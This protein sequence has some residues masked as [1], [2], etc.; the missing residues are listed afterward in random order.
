MK[1]LLLS[2]LAIQGSS[3][4]AMIPP[5]LQSVSIM[6]IQGKEQFS[7]L[8]LHFVETT[9]VVTLVNAKKDGFWMQDP[10]GDGDPTTSD[11]LYVTG[12]P[13]VVTPA[14][15]DSVRILGRVEEEQRG[16]ELPRTR[17]FAVQSPEVLSQ[18]TFLPAPVSL[19]RLPDVSIAEGIAFW[20]ALEG[21]R[22]SV[23]NAVVISPTNRYR[24]FNVL[25]PG[26][27]VPGSGYYSKSGRLLVRSLGGEK[28]DYNPER[29]MIGDATVAKPILVSA[30]DRL[31]SLVGVV[32]Y[33]FNYYKVQ[34][35]TESVKVEAREIPKPPVS[36]RTGP[37]G[38]FVI[39]TYNFWDY[40]DSIPNGKNE[41]YIYK[42]EQV[43]VRVT[44]MAQSFI[45]ELKLPQIVAVNEVE[46]TAMDKV[47]ER[48]NTLAGT[49]YKTAWQTTS[50]WR[51]LSMG[52]IYDSD[53]VKLESLSQI[54][55]AGVG[56]AFGQKS[57]IGNREPLV[58]VFSVGEGIP[59]VTVIA[60]KIKTKRMEDS[61]F[62][63][64]PPFRFT[65]IQRKAQ[66]RVIRKYLNALF[67][68]NPD[69]YV[70]VTGDLADYD[71]PEPGEGAD[72]PLA[73][74]K[75][76]DGEVP[77]TNLSGR[78]EEAERYDYIF[79]GGGVLVS[80]IL[81]S[82][83]LLKAFVA[84]DILHFNTGFPDQLRWDVS[85]PLKASDR[86]PLEARFNLVARKK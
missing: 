51:G 80:H 18:G 73:I 50:D 56:G 33:T 13:G 78:E 84:A 79:Q 81:V 32:D 52:F 4:E 39:T 28:V 38:N 9:G 53:R 59:P 34:P 83:A 49:H 72:Y 77:L 3:E 43:E 30:G 17:L 44:K 71:F 66:M 20:E 25:A 57:A 8:N 22:V 64:M 47:A 16:N 23:Q 42:P 62:S 11:G 37:P 12:I 41:P 2:L 15:G 1:Y 6:E 21:M 74:L 5:P 76:V 40:F 26:N 63:I 19:T 48:I 58:G 75:G 85:T 7:P 54:S 86:D 60:N 82:P 61:P 45:Q 70:A 14:V 55:S 31:T 69:A 65:E 36:V 35:E 68:K 27:A 67:E 29:I 46:G 10:V 24:E